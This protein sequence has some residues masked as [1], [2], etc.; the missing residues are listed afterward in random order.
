MIV[1]PTEVYKNYQ[2]GKIRKTAAITY[3]ISFLEDQSN[4]RYTVDSIEILGEMQVNSN[5]LYK[6]LENLVL[7]TTTY[8][9]DVINAA[10][11][12]LTLNFSKKCE[13]PLI[14]FLE[15][16]VNNYRLIDIFIKISD[17][18]W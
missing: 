9:V 11:K 15:T 13:S 12:V 1:S 8:N 4:W 2:M 17:L 10:I 16:T 6:L 3:L 7:L 18:I 5:E 14:S